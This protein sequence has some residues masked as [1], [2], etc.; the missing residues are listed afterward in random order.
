MSCEPEREFDGLGIR[1]VGGWD[2]EIVRP[3]K[4]GGCGGWRGIRRDTGQVLRTGE[5]TWLAWVKKQEA[6][7]CIL[8]K[9]R[10]KVPLPHASIHLNLIRKRTHHCS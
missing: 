6:R 5:G 9:L 3:G 1:V 7:V 4:E 8:E 2:F 10:Q